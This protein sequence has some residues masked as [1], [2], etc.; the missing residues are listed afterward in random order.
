[1]TE[2]SY[3]IPINKFS[4][5]LRSELYRLSDQNSEVKNLLLLT[6]CKLSDESFKSLIKQ[7]H[8]TLPSSSFL[9]LEIKARIN[10]IKFILNDKDKIKCIQIAIENYFRIY[11]E[12]KEIKYSIRAFELVRK[13]KSVYTDE[14]A[15]FE[16]EAIDMFL[17]IDNSYYQTIF[18][19]TII[20]LIQDN[21]S[22]I[23]Q[24][25]DY[26][27]DKLNIKLQENDFEDASNYIKILSVLKHFNNNEYKIQIA[28]C[29]EKEADYFVSQKEP[30]TYY[31][32]ILDIYT[33]ALKEIKGICQN[34][35]LNSRLQ[36]KVKKEQSL[37]FEMLTKI[38]VSIDIKPNITEIIKELN[39][40]NFHSAFN[41]LINFPII[42]N[43]NL[44]STLEHRER[45]FLNQY[46]KDYI[47]ITSKGTVSGISNEGDYY[48]NQSREYY[49]T[50]TIS[51]LKE[52]KFIMDINHELISKNLVTA[53]VIKCNSS[54]IPKDREYFFI[55]GLYQGF[56]NNFSLASHL[57]I[58]QIENSLKC[59]IELN[60]RNTIKLAEEI[61]NDNTLGGILSIEKNNKMLDGICNSNL[62]LELNNF[63][64]DGN[65]VN[66]RNRLCH[67]LI[68][69]FETEYFG[70]YLWWLTLKM[71]KQT[72]KYFKSPT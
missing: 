23:K 44:T 51:F 31:P 63:L 52:L 49:R 45:S 26:A 35:E 27:L 62:L 50:I 59:I 41:N 20:F 40:N 39:I 38:G 56:Q 66:F 14:L 9:N 53:M 2:L 13:V 71:I 28:L 12:T 19:N 8:F 33:K 46:F 22:R 29:L 54:F 68:S 34:E 65:S 30:N 6:T 42:D 7:N 58:P 64:C 24:L 36:T 5:E 25:T 11:N 15:N 61:Q 32:R 18:L 10:D 57:L 70:F 55:E 21:N 48:L 37:H 67:G 47:R 60:G 69:P 17:A 43:G 16:L 72:E 4:S 3:E 1:M